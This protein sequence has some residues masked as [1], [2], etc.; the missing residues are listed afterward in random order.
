[1]ATNAM[2]NELIYQQIIKDTIYEDI[3]IKKV[4]Y[5]LYN[6]THLLIISDIHDIALE[7]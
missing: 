1:M 7:I 3:N 6:N 2:H 5:F 4:V